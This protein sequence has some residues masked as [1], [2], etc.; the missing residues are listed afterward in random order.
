MGTKIW[1]TVFN[2][3]TQ[4]RVFRGTSAEVKEFLANQQNPNLIIKLMGRTVVDV[5]ILE[6]TSM[7]APPNTRGFFK[8][9][10]R[11]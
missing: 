10:F 6:N 8:R 1:Y 3:Q 5:S 2:P 9:I 11:K 4:E 7:D